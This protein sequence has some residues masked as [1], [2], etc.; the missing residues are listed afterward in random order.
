MIILG[1]D[2]GTSN[3]SAALMINSNLRLVKEPTKQGYSFPSSIYL[4]REGKILVGQ[5]AETR[6]FNDITRYRRE[7][8][9]DLLQNYPYVLGKQG[10]YQF[11]PQQLVIEVIKTLKREAD[12]MVIALGEE[13]ISEAVVTIP[14]TYK[15]NKKDLMK[16]AAEQA[17]FS[18]VHLLEEP[19]AAASYYNHQN[20]KT[21]KEGDIILVYDLG[22][23]TFD[24][25][26]IKKQ[27]TG[28]QIL[29]QPLGKDPCGGIDFDR[30]IFQDVKSLCDTQLQEKLSHKNQLLEKNEFLD[31]CQ[32]IKHQFSLDSTATGNIPIS[33][34]FYQLE[35]SQFNQMISPYIEQTIMICEDLVKSAGLES[36]NV[37]KVLMVGG[38]CRIPYIQDSI[39]NRL[40]S[41]VL[42]IDEPELAVCQGATIYGE[43][44]KSLLKKDVKKDKERKREYY[45]KNSRGDP[46]AVFE[47]D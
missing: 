23:G 15:K 11:T 7:F 40:C 44:L 24:A 37:S 26:L 43:N 25:T 36:N 34:K 38:S 21:F 35:N 10:E 6:K 13:P 42:L 20:P 8:K 4:D 22:G 5:I 19:V 27:G 3:S 46:F 12:K 39:K 16:E 41:A 1:I 14:A 17:G 47:I 45:V 29:G 31:F 30:E 28:F 32:G 2:F 33:R 18:L 9:R